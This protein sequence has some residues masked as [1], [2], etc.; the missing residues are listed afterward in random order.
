MNK[1]ILLVDDVQ[2]FIEIQKEFLHYSNVTVLTARNGVE[3]LEVVRVM[4]PDLVF[5]DLE[6]PLLDGAACCQA[7]KSDP[8]LTGIPVVIISSTITEEAR[9]KCF[10]A[11]CAHY[12]PKP[13]DRDMFL[14]VA[15]SFIPGID[16]R[17]K[18]HKCEIEAV[19]TLR[20]A[21]VSC[22]IYDLSV[23]GTYIVSNFDVAPRDVIQVH[24]TLP[25]GT[26]IDC[27]GRVA[28]VNNSYEKF[29]RGFGVKFAMLSKEAKNAL[30]SFREAALKVHAR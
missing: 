12:L 10:S 8:A 20:E 6:M 17:E 18:R 26:K 16:R 2:M 19:F 22:R 30:V 11:G 4:R 5:M 3:A 29:H 14:N 27:H 25:D 13:L 1:K 28:W 9:N 24:F 15:R 7:I 23:G 21:D